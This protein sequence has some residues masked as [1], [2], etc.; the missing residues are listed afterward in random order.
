M[1][2]LVT[3][4]QGYLH[5][6]TVML[7]S[8]SV[9]HPEEPLDVYVMNKALLPEHF[10][11]IRRQLNHPL[12]RLIDVKVCEEQLADAPVTNRYPIEMYYRIFAARYLPDT[13]DR[14]LYLDPD[15]VVRGSLT[16]LYQT[17]MGYAFFAAASHVPKS[18]E[19]LNSLR[20][21]SRSD[22]PYINSGVMLLN[23]ER[24]RREQ[25][26]EQVFRY[27]EE[28]KAALF[29][30]DQDVISALYG[31]RILPLD[32]WIYNMTERL[33]AAAVLRPQLAIDLD[34][35]SAHSRIIH[36]CGRNKPWKE[37]YVG[38]L[39]RFYLEYEAML[40]PFSP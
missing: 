35:V 28:N 22:G 31:D 17:S 11:S 1:N 40:P 33:L 19:R 36:Y 18:L 13:L 2:L 5:P 15:L 20:L 34:W 26:M 30:P 27:I 37:H 21:H 39:D 8:L 25:D 23:L 6:L 14:V 16:E 38:R 12:L 4:D 9:T 32:P 7:K 24:L 29:L 3:L 10:D